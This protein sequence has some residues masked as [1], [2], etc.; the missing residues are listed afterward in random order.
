M[1]WREIYSTAG[2]DDCGCQVWCD[3][4]KGPDDGEEAVEVCRYRKSGPRL[5]GR[6]HEGL[7][8]R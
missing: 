1:G 7:H 5:A 8:I 4:E 3:E 2:R 6:S